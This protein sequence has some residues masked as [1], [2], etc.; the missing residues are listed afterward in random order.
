[1]CWSYPTKVNISQKYTSSGSSR[2]TCALNGE[3]H[4]RAKLK[5]LIYHIPSKLPFNNMKP[6]RRIHPKQ[7][8]RDPLLHMRLGRTRQ[9]I[10][11]IRSG[12]C[13]TPIHLPIMPHLWERSGLAESVSH[14]KH[15]YV[16]DLSIER[17]AFVWVEVG[18][19]ARLW[20]CCFVASLRR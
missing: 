12:E 2:T 18:S 13:K 14:N 4:A 1:M 9:R 11:Y 15:E 8:L 20:R 16:P 17:F 6:Q 3:H 19:A 7:S 10:A 5:H